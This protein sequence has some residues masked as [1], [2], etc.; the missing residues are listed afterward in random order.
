[1]ST[2]NR[3]ENNMKQTR[4]SDPDKIWLEIMLNAQKA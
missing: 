2:T 1:M 3:S 4:Y